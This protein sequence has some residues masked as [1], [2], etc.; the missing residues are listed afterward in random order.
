[1]N[2]LY[3][4]NKLIAEYFY[5]DFVH[6]KHQGDD[7]K[8][9]DVKPILETCRGSYS[10]MAHLLMEEYELLKY[11]ESYNALV[12]VVKEIQNSK[13]D[14]DKYKESDGWYAYYSMESLLPYADIEQVYEEVIKFITWYNNTFKK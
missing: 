5:P 2:L 14:I 1:M 13:L 4:K 11:H 3:Q 8:K 6:P 7:W 9:E 10:A 12:P